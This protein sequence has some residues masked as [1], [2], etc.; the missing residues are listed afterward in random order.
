MP[1]ALAEQLLEA[2]RGGPS[3]SGLP[4]DSE[5]VV[6]EVG[7]GRRRRC[8]RPGTQQLLRASPA[9][10][11]RRP[12]RRRWRRPWRRRAA[13]AAGAGTITLR[14]P[15]GLV[16]G[17]PADRRAERHLLGR[18]H[19]DAQRRTRRPRAPSPPRRSCRRAAGS[20]ICPGTALS[21][22]V[23]RMTYVT[24]NRPEQRSAPGIQSGDM[25]AS[26]PST[27]DS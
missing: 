11:G 27:S 1:S 7:D 23:R 9:R 8:R 24:A 22:I 3:C 2:G 25:P 6:A 16:A 20:G 12:S 26:G 13:G 15:C 14:W 10:S 17:V 4:A 5:P 21:K 18:D 19:D